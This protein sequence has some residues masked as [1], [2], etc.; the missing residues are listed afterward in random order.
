[1]AS[2]TFWSD[3]LPSPFFFNELESHFSFSFV[4]TVYLWGFLKAKVG[5]R[6]V[7]GQSALAFSGWVSWLS[8]QCGTLLYWN[9]QNFIVP[10]FGRLYRWYGLGR[11]VSCDGSYCASKFLGKFFLS[12]C[13]PSV[14][15]K[16]G[17]CPCNS[18]PLWNR[19]Y[20][21]KFIFTLRM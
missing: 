12:F 19:V 11:K 9:T 4:L 16:I 6:L 1:M 18:I 10:N 13:P 2:V 8:Y 15:I 21:F 17:K 7:W 5:D 20:F 3:F 14:N